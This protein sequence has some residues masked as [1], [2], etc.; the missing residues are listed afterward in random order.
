MATHPYHLCILIF[1]TAFV[2]ILAH[3]NDSTSYLNDLRRKNKIVSVKD[4]F[5][6]RNFV[7]DM[8]QLSADIFEVKNNL[9]EEAISNPKFEVK[10]WINA[11]FSTEA[12]IVTSKEENSTA[13]VIFKGSDNFD[14]WLVNINIKLE[15]SKFT[16]APVSVE[17]H[18]GFQDA[19]F[20]QD[21]VGEIEDKVLELVGEDGK[22]IFTGHSLG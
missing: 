18:R 7:L 21:I 11:K 22:V 1:I 10:L 12:M 2:Q 8:M 4:S 15:K 14:D 3:R 20:D 13:F 5:P 6:D 16:N 17:V 19:L 9:P